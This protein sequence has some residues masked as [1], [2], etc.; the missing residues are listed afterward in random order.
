TSREKMAAGGVSYDYAN[1]VLQG[2]AQVRAQELDT[3]LTGL[4]VWN[5]EPGDG[6]GGTA[7]A[8]ERWQRSGLAVEVVDPL[9]PATPPRPRKRAKPPKAARGQRTHVMAMLFA[10]AVHFSRL[11]E[12]QVPVFVRRFLGA[13]ARVLKRYP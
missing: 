13:I 2:L 11:K 10:D 6:G 9:A 1:L 4:A 5:G 7:S 8:V 12:E 3:A